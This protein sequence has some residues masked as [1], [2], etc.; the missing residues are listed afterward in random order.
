MEFALSECITDLIYLYGSAKIFVVTNLKR[1]VFYVH[2]KTSDILTDNS[3]PMVH[4]GQLRLL[5]SVIRLSR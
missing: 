4:L 1:H 3:K 2:I 5:F